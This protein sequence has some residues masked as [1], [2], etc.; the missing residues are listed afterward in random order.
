M[1]Q[2]SPLS[3]RSVIQRQCLAV[4]PIREDMQLIRH[5]AFFTTVDNAVIN[6]LVF[7][8]RADAAVELHAVNQVEMIIMAKAGPMT[9]T[10]LP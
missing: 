1:E 10:I 5:A 4:L 9:Q 6:M 2:R 7:N 8:E 3:N